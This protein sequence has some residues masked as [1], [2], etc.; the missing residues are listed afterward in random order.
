MA[1]PKSKTSKQRKAKRRSSV[2]RLDAP[3]LSVCPK[4]G[5]LR[6]AHTVCKACGTYNGRD[7]LKLE[8]GK[9]KKK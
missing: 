2:W 5:A 6:R 9:K 4:C 7:V 3:N 8:E 1:V